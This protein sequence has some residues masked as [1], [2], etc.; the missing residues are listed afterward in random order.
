MNNDIT[1]VTTFSDKGYNDYGKLFLESC[2]QYLEPTV[3]I[4]VYKDNVEIPAQP[5]TKILPLEPSIPDLTEFKKR[6]AHRDESDV[7]F[8]YQSVR[9]SHKVYALYHAATTVSSRY[10]IWLDSDT[11]LYSDVTVAYLRHF[12]PEGTFVG[13]LG[14]GGDAFSEC[15]FMIYDLT[16]SHTKDFFNKFKWYYDTDELYKLKEWHDSYIFDVVRKEFEAANKIQ[17]V[18]LS[19]A[20]NKHHFNAVL[21]GHIMHLKGDRKNKRAKMLEKAMRRKGE[22]AKI[23]PSW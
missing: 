4:V 14:R 9:F 11:E 6:N 17:G 15:G 10:L 22:L 13:Y 18:N 5:N 3:A 7:K 12:L 20:F 23:K 16:N 2:K 21:D 8:Q 1:I 19:A